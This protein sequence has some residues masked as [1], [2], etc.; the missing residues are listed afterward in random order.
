MAFVTRWNPEIITWNML[1]FNLLPTSLFSLWRALPFFS[2]CVIGSNVYKDGWPIKI[3]CDLLQT[4]L[5][6]ASGKQHNIL[7]PCSRPQSL[8]SVTLTIE[9]PIATAFLGSTLLCYASEPVVVPKTWLLLCSPP[10]RYHNDTVLTE[11]NGHREILLSLSMRKTSS[12]W[13]GGGMSRE[14]IAVWD[15]QREGRITE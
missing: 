2:T 12:G 5:N 1:L 9:S 14:M 6:L 4:S 15:D 3:F 8:M 10:N 7:E 11:G 13:G